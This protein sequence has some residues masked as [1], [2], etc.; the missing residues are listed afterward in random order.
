[1]SHQSS[2]DEL[3][4]HVFEA[5]RSEEPAYVSLIGR[6]IGTIEIRKL[7]A[8]GG[9]GRVFVGYDERLQREVAL[10]AVRPDRW[11]QASR[12][13]L[14]AEARALSQLNH[15][16]ICAIYGYVPGDESD[17]LVLELIRGETLQKAI[18]EESLDPR[19]R[20][21]V[22]QQIASALG[23]A[24]AQ[25]IIHRDLKPAN[26]MLTPEG[27]VKVLDFGIARFLQREP[28]AE[29]GAVEVEDPDVLPL[30]ARTAAGKIIGTAEWMSPEQAKGEPLTAASDMYSFGLLLQLLFTGENPYEPGLNHVDILRRAQ[31][32]QSRPV[33][34]LGTALASL[35]ERLKSPDPAKRPTAAEVQWRLRRIR[36]APRR[37]LRRL[38]AAAAVLVAVLG[39]VKYTVDLRS[40]RD[41]ALQARR[42]AELARKQQEETTAFLLDVFKVS[43]PGEARGSTVT[44]RELLD[45]G[46][47]KVRASLQSQPAAQAR[48]L[49]TMG[50]VYLR[51]GLYDEAR[52]LLEQAFQLSQRQGGSP[53]QQVESLE[54]LA[55]V[56]QAEN[57]PEALARLEKALA[58]REAIH[59]AQ[60]PDA[61][62]LLNNL[63]VQHAMAGDLDRAEAFFQRALSIRTATLGPVHPDVAVSLNNLAGVRIARDQPE[64]AESL[65][66]RALAI[67]RLTLPPDHPDVSGN[68]EAL[69]LVYENSGRLAKAVALHRQA[70]A[71]AEKSLGRE[72]PSTLLIV[73]NLGETFARAG[74][75]REAE[76]FLR[77]AV[78]AREKVLG[79]AHPNLANSLRL[80]AELYR[81]EHR[82]SDADPL[83]RRALA[84]YRA[85]YPPD[86]PNLAKLQ[87]SYDQMLR[88]AGG[89]GKTA[90]ASR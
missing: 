40:Q 73:T 28:A 32:A 69:A 59:Q 77:R 10:K 35:I 48:I 65:L 34:G 2:T 74:R 47:A 70:L 19:A 7:L 22:A 60:T 27:G 66:R 33:E 12:A 16:N 58:L 80:L 82:F 30:P 11:S 84:I 53:L 79:P 72:H 56:D 8:E 37:W 1:M 81:D 18:D 62:R 44:A 36:E 20:M 43:D 49:D 75:K 83:Y 23:A 54:H 63:G 29:P 90:L 50:Q 3:E 64:R 57:Q 86:H 87:D 9:M 55:L 68:L 41:A 26:V 76:A 21:A 78:Q 46:A 6:K 13:R 61:A 24:H 89:P 85:A 38:A 67:R 52:P 17:F 14:L 39:A 4:G 31:V 71:I 15:P 5:P 25:G 42:E 45:R 51:L 88:D